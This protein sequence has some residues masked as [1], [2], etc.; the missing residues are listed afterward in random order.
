MH[1]F[2]NP[3]STDT[4]VYYLHYAERFQEDQDAPPLN[5]A[6]T[7]PPLSP[8]SFGIVDPPSSLPYLL[9]HTCRSRR[10]R[11]P[12]PSATFQQPS[13]ARVWS[14]R[15]DDNF[16][17]ANWYGPMRSRHVKSLPRL[18]FVLKS[19]RNRHKKLIKLAKLVS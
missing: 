3:L 7:R 15:S 6:A 5:T 10:R 13:F 19:N 11:M 4:V 16:Y 1:V 12:S 9:E 14:I 8:R 17:L 18:Q 2:D